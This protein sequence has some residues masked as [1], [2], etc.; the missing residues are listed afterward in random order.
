MPEC[1]GECE[2]AKAE[3]GLNVRCCEVCHEGEVGRPRQWLDGESYYRV[4]CR[5]LACQVPGVSPSH[6]AA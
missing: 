5:V 1:V 3:L 2:R 6:G 4:C